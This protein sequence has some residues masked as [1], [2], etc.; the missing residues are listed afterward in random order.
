MSSVPLAG[1][2]ATTL[3]P[4]AA[5]PRAL[6]LLLPSTLRRPPAQEISGAVALE[7]FVV[8]V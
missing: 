3:L 4:V 8:L 1:W 5:A 2:N 6:V 7:A